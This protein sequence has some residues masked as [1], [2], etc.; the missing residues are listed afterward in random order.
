MVMDQIAGSHSDLAI[1]I[2]GEN[3]L[4]TR[5]IA[6]KVLKTVKNII[7]ERWI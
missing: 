3:Q 7:N 4:E 2:Y 6:E 5:K 1:K